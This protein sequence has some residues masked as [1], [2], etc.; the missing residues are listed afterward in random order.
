MRRSFLAALL[1][2]ATLAAA[3]AGS[4][5][6]DGGAGTET[7]GT[8]GGGAC[9]ADREAQ[10]PSASM[11]LQMTWGSACQTDQECKDRLGD[12][13]AVCDFSAVVYE[14]PGGYCTKPC[15]VGDDPSNTQMSF[16][17]DDPECD[18]A[19]GVAC[20]G[21]NGIYTRCAIPCTDDSNCGREGY[22][23][24]QMPSIGGPNDPSFCLM[25]DCCEMNCD[26]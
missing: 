6:D 4:G 22:F 5:G 11:D 24:R 12:P 1:A 23:C 15:V 17:L 14:L 8:T 25:D 3:C 21:A 9:Y 7:A 20:V 18:P 26:P 10:K 19:G 2:T 16:E 13:D